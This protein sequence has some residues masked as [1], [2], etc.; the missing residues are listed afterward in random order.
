MA[1]NDARAIADVSSGVILATVSIA[2]PPERVFRAITEPGEIVRWWGSDELY[3]TRQDSQGADGRMRARAEEIE[4]L[5]D[6]V[7][8]EARIKA[9][10]E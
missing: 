2:A 9:V 8:D 10:S 4:R 3:R 6:A 1:S 7:L 5:L